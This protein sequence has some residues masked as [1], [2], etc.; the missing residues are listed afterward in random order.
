[1]I[2]RL[3]SS[4]HPRIRLLWASALIGLTLSF[5]AC[6]N[7]FG[8]GQGDT[9]DPGV[10]GPSGGVITQDDRDRVSNPNYSWETE[11]DLD[12]VAS[13]HQVLSLFHLE[14]QAKLSPVNEYQTILDQFLDIGDQ[15]SWYY[16]PTQAALL[17]EDFTTSNQQGIFGFS[18]Q[19]FDDTV[20]VN[21]VLPGSGAEAAGLKSGDVI[22]KISGQPLTNFDNPLEAIA[23]ELT[24][25]VGTAVT[26]EVLRDGAFIILS[27]TKSIIDIPT[28]WVD[29]LTPLTSIIHIT[30]FEAQTLEETTDSISGTWKEFRAALE[31]TS[32]E[33]VTVID[34]RGNPGGFVNIC[35]GMIDELLNDG[36]FFITRNISEGVIADDTIRAT[37]GGLATNREFILLANEGSASCA[38]LFIQGVKTNKE[39]PLIG[40]TTYGKGIAQG[41]YQTFYQGLVR[42]T[43]T[44]YFY[45]G[46]DSYHT[47]GHI[48]DYDIDS[49]IQQISKAIELANEING[50]GAGS[51]LD[52]EEHALR[53]QQTIDNHPKS[54]RE[55]GAILFYPEF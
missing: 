48:P 55:P 3:H 18:Y 17:I 32:D 28:A 16:D 13:V 37:R 54:T 35:T 6:S 47:I 11:G 7:L 26:L 1:M 31:A 42:A 9:R 36:T 27:M 14:G 10:Y 44:Q 23:N 22:F 21:Y 40:K 43:S 30:A 45:E 52:S 12:E 51:S 38:E 4:F 33:D 15:F 20:V 29:S 41:F 19:L 25:D 24:V 8:D 50:V 53:I 49:P 5:S 46:G 39:A 34:L 2:L